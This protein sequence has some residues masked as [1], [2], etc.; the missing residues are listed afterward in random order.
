MMQT[1]AA[2]ATENR[3]TASAVAACM[4]PL[5]LKPLMT[6]ECGFEDESDFSGD[7]SAQLLAAAAAAN[8][9]QAIITIL[10]EE[11]DSIFEVFNILHVGYLVSLLI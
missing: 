8:N 6:G 11:Y 10:L 3:M 9:A 2:H 4:A 5:L 1:V 7:N